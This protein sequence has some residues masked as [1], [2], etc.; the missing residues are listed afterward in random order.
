MTQNSFDP[1]VVV[2]IYKTYRILTPLLA[3]FPK[4]QRYSLGQTM[5]R[6]LLTMLEHIFEANAM[7]SPLR[8]APLLKALAKCELVKILVRLSCEESIILDTQ[9]FQLIAGLHEITKMLQGWINYTRNLP[10]KEKDD[11]SQRPRG[12]RQD[13]DSH[14]QPRSSSH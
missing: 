7:P 5:D 4:P 12:A 13:S 3:S 1:S 11:S 2:K 14:Q 8:E 10:N 9:Y 6:G